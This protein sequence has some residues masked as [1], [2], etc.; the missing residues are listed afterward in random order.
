MLKQYPNIVLEGIGGSGKTTISNFIQSYYTEQNQKFVVQHFRYPFGESDI[1]KYGYQH[2][3]FRLLFEMIEK[4]NSQ[5]VA[6][7]LDRSWIGEYVWGDIYRHLNPVYLEALEN[8]YS[9]LNNVILN[10]YANPSIVLRRLLERKPN[11]AEDDPYFNQY[12]KPIDAVIDIMNKFRDIISSRKDFNL[13][14]FN[15]N[16]SGEF[17]SVGKEEILSHI[18]SNIIQE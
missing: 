13:K 10:V 17:S 18:N 4:F 2:G 14:S 7:I 6:V 15:Y 11:I 1:E 3:Q 5:N 16:A 9:H 8:D 12:D